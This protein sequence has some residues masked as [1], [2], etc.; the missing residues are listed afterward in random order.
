[1]PNVPKT[2]ISRFRI[3]SEEWRDFGHAVATQDKDRSIVLREFVAWYL[4][5]SGNKAIKR[6]EVGE[7][8]DAANAEREAE[9]LADQSD[10]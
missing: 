6:P 8:I 3:D 5:R 7:W 10:A 2:P 1:M 4:R 9:R